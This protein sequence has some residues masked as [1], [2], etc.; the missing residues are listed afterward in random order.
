MFISCFN[1]TSLKIN[2]VAVFND[3]IQA[4]FILENVENTGKHNN[5]NNKKSK[6]TKKQQ[7][8]FGN[9]PS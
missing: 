5:K 2:N 1:Q 9:N 8:N 7:H 3:E 6:Q 4:F